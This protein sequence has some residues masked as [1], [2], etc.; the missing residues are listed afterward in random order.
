[1]LAVL[2]SRDFRFLWTARSIHEVS[3]RME[4]LVL[5][6]LILSMTDS[7][8]QVGLI[9]VFLNLPRPALALFAGLLADRLDRRRILIW[10]HATYLGL[11]TAI[12]LLLITGVIQPWHIFMIV[13][14]QGAARVTDDPARR[15]AIFDLAGHEHITGAMS[16]ETMT[17]NWGRILG[18]LAGGVLIAGTGFTGAYAVIV[19]FDLAALLLI[20]RMQLPHQAQASG[21]GRSMARD[22]REG[23]EHSLN[24]R[25]VL[26]VLSMSLIVNA[27]VFPI[28]YFIPVIASDLLLVGPVLGG[29]LGSAEG[30]GTLIGALVIGMKRDIRY[31]GRLFCAGALTVASAVALIAWSPWFTLSFALLSF[32]GLGQAGFSTMQSTIL[33]LETRPEMRGRV[34]GAQGTVNGLGHLIGGSEI[35]A[36]AS[37]LGI[38]VAIGINAGAGLIL[39]LMV[40]ALTPLI[41]RQVGTVLGGT[42]SAADAPTITEPGSDE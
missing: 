12:L 39:I 4:L 22:M 40:I 19:A 3:R 11:A 30:I 9:A 37:A 6:Y 18:P 13:L 10:A 20:T 38:G 27:L 14:V 33:L 34:M 41:R 28:Q 7:A 15:T 31:H 42:I 32:G 5:G 21:S 8:F 29:L 35:G 16:L 25:M 36:V 24:N 2:Q 17:N 23:L 26:G 1:M